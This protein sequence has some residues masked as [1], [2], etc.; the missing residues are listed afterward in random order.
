MRALIGTLTLLLLLAA[1]GASGAQVVRGELVDSADVPVDEVLATLLDSA[2]GELRTARSD[3]TGIFHLLAP[4]GGTYRVALTRIGYNPYTTG[5]LLLRDGETLVIGVRMTRRP[6]ALSTMTIIT[7]TRREW[8]RDGWA[9]RKA[10]GA[11]VFLTGDD[12]RA[13]KATTVAEALGMVDGL[14]VRYRPLPELETTRGNRCIQY[15][16]NNLAMPLIPGEHPSLTLDRMMGADRVM[17]IEV[18]R[19]YKEVPPVFRALAVQNVPPSDL[20]PPIPRRARTG[21]IIGVPETRNCGLIN[22]WTVKAW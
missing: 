17:G 14:Q 8:G 15:V 7:R 20:P 3:E 6:Q 16:V 21:T 12:I 19:D 13:R 18:Y 2:G 5:S 11:G 22:I 9:I 1:P 10:L 4:H